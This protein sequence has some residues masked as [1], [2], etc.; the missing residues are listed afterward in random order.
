MSET[1]TP[2]TRAARV[3]G[4]ALGAVLAFTTSAYAE[5]AWVLWQEHRRVGHVLA[6]TDVPL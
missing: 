1:P 6:G 2:T 4:A 3:C 5:C